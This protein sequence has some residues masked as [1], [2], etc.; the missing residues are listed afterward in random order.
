MNVSAIRDEIEDFNA[1]ASANME[2]AD[3]MDMLSM[4][5]DMV[6]ETTGE[7]DRVDRILTE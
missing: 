4:L 7:M 2:E 6:I 3:L 1:K 5:E